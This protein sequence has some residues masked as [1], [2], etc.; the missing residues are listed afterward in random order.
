MPQHDNRRRYRHEPVAL[1]AG[2]MRAL[3]AHLP[4]DMA[5]MV[6]TL[7]APSSE[8]GYE[9][10]QLEADRFVVTGGDLEQECVPPN[11]AAG[12]RTG[13]F[14]DGPGATFVLYADFLPGDYDTDG[15]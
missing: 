13:R 15:R 1:T 3:L 2:Q 12:E 7:T 11:W 14:V 8:P 10:A 6:S 4:D 9:I 5:V